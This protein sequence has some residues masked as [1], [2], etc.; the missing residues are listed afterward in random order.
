MLILSFIVLTGF[1]DSGARGLQ[2]A[3]MDDRHDLFRCGMEAL[4]IG[5]VG[6]VRAIDHAHHD[7]LMDSWSYESF[8]YLVIP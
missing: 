2:V 3:A 8:P 7:W 6:I 5:S 4:Q 1:E